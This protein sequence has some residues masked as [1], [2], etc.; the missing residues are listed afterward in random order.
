MATSKDISLGYRTHV[1]GTAKPI[2]ESKRIILYNKYQFASNSAYSRISVYNI[3]RIYE[4]VS[5]SS[6]SLVLDKNS[7][8]GTNFISSL[9]FGSSIHVLIGS[10]LSESKV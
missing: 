9:S 7:S 2:I 5:S 8:I 3:E 10:P 6:L 4:V 1:V